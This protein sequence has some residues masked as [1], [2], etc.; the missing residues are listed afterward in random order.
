MVRAKTELEKSFKEDPNQ[1]PYHFARGFIAVGE[2]DK[3]LSLLEK[4]Y[5]VRDIRIWHLK[6][7]PTLD[8]VRNDPR[9][10]ALLKKANLESF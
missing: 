1:S 2:Y 3:G 5:E 10:K 8:S 7:D 9:F 6:V 4:A